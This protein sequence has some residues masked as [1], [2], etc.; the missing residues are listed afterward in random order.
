MIADLASTDRLAAAC[1]PPRSGASWAVRTV[2]PVGGAMAAGTDLTRRSRGPASM[3][4]SAD[5]RAPRARRGSG[6]ARDSGLFP[7]PG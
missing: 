6:D 2:V 1:P 3:G 7:R 4:G 5:R